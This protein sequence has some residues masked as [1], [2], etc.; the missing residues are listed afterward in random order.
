VFIENMKQVM[1]IPDGHEFRLRPVS[2]NEA[3]RSLADLRL[4]L[5]PCESVE[6]GVQLM[7][8]K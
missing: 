8:A 7:A 3:R 1:S 4:S 6:S 5:P 2:S